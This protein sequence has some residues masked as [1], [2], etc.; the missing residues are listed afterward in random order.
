LAWRRVKSDRS[1]P[2]RL[3]R[4]F[5]R[6]YQASVVESQR[7]QEDLARLFRAL[8]ARG[9]EPILVKGWSVARKYGDAALRPSCD[10]DISVP[11]AALAAAYRALAEEVLRRTPASNIDLHAGVP[12]LGDRTWDELLGRS[13]TVPLRG[14]EVRVLAPEDELRLVCLHLWRHQGYR[15]LWLC[16]V[17]VLLE[18]LPHDFDWRL[19]LGGRQW[20]SAVVRTV[21]GLAGRL[22]GARLPVLDGTS[23]A[24]AAWT[25]TAVL[26][27]WGAELALSTGRTQPAGTVA[28]LRDRIRSRWFDPF[29]ACLRMRISPYAPLG[30]LHAAAVGSWPLQWGFR[31]RERLLPPPSPCPR[32]STGTTSTNPHHSRPAPFLP[33][34]LCV[35][36]SPRAPS[37]LRHSTFAL[38]HSPPLSFRGQSGLVTIP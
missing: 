10:H 11:P 21:I 31:I 14:E 18:T 20:E 25:E 23:L 6:E 3:A 19:C 15:P 33:L 24:P 34:P 7:N 12:D 22:L 2:P 1:V 32:P 27:Q 36:A 9:V 38:R 29:R 8:R 35:S 26:N 5:R 17:A 37:S 13:Q 16:D 30:V 4:D 28:R